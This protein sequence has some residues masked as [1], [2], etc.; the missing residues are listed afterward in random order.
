LVDFLARTM[1]AP[2]L[3]GNSLLEDVGN[4]DNDLLFNKPDL[5]VDDTAIAPPAVTLKASDKGPGSGTFRKRIKEGLMPEV[6]DVS[7]I[8]DDPKGD[9]GLRSGRSGF[10][11]SRGSPILVH[12]GKGSPPFTAGRSAYTG[13]ERRDMVFAETPLWCGAPFADRPHDERISFGEKMSRDYYAAP[14]DPA[15]EH[16]PYYEPPYEFP[17]DDRSTADISTVESRSPPEF[18]VK[19]RQ[20][21][22]KH[23]GWESTQAEW[24]H[25]QLRV[26]KPPAPV[27]YVPVPVPM[28]VPPSRDGAM[29]NDP[30]ALAVPTGQKQAPVMIPVPVPCLCRWAEMRRR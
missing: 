25:E 28:G 11:G 24:P 7:G 14:Y 10:S 13:R 15:D 1:L 8:Q 16:V 4:R 26:E 27:Q 20:N 30:E 17:Y 18:R 9:V 5:F 22:D 23:S 12:S 21:H 6:L 3:R 19:P 29:W 2:D